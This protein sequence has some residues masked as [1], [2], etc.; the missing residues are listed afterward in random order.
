M[1]PTAALE[2][3]GLIK[4][5][6]GLTAT[7]NVNLQLIGNELHAII[8]PNGAGKSTLIGQLSGEIAPSAGSIHFFGQDV[9]KLGVAQRANLGL[10]RS[11]QI[12]QICKELSTLD[13]VLM[14]ALARGTRNGSDKPGLFGRLFRPLHNDRTLIDA[15]SS[16]LQLV[17]LGARATTLCADLA[18]GEQRQLE[19]AMALALEPKILLLDEPLAGMSKA[20][21]DVM[22]E[23]LLRLKGHYPILLIEHDMDAV[24][25]LADR[26]SVLVYGAIIAT[27]TPAAV[28]ADP[29]VRA[30]YLGDE[31]A[32]ELTT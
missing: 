8:G 30:A 7:D 31:A 29:A 13:N 10:A 3:R 19:I 22:V 5:F 26:V 27:N 2:T 25:A 16:A 6:G 20:E 14:A 15:A 4:R 21:S 11:Y 24:F 12:S 23:L 1:N 32:A 17:G 9:S 18:H 28:R